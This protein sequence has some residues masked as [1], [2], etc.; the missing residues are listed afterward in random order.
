MSFRRL[1]VCSLAA[2]LAGAALLAA[3]GGTGTTNS[4]TGSNTGSSSPAVISAGDA[5]MSSVL[6]ALVTV[7]AV[8]MTSSS[9]TVQLLD[10]PRPIELTH[11]GGIRAPLGLH[12]LPLGTYTSLS[13]TVSAATI[14][15]ID[16]TGKVVTANATIPSGKDTSTITLNPSLDVTDTGA[17]DIR[18]DFDLQ[19]SLDLTGSTVTFT[20]TLSAAVARV[21]DEDSGHRDIHVDGTVT[22]TSTTAN[23]I[24]LTTDDTGL[25]VTLNVSNSTKFEDSLT[26]ASLQVGASISTVDDLNSDGTISA[27]VVEVADGDGDD[28][29]GNHRVDGGIVTAVSLDANNNLTGFSM[30]VRNSVSE[31]NLGKTLTVQVNSATDIKIS[32]NA[33]NAGMTTFDQT[34]IFA[35][36]ALWVAGAKV[37]GQTDTVLASEI[38]PAQ[39]NPF[40]L[41]TAAVTAGASG[42]FVI[43]FVIDVNTAFD[44]FLTTPISAVTVDT[45]SSTI[46][47]GNVSSSSIASL[48]AGSPLIVRGFLSESA[49]AATLF[50][51]H[52]HGVSAG[53]P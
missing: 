3:C 35:G 1:P 21:K 36:Q 42:G 18:F 45:N 17:T 44:R 13:L 33:T 41:T 23:T 39:V 28:N 40:G 51:T 34:Q 20:P 38:R 2:V 24:T 27:E 14:T 4:N 6:A 48:S 22:A 47:D 30:V 16:S 29:D 11:L 10:Q 31:N 32:M 43:P 8:S 12:A 7:S 19:D 37:Q 9:G 52:V 25:S 26:L 15:Y 5:P 49:G 50:S 46:F 53:R